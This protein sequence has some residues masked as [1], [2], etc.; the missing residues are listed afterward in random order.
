MKK[1]GKIRGIVGTVIFHVLLLLVL[2]FFGLTT[3]LPLPGEEGVEVNLGYTDDGMENIQQ[4]EAPKTTPPAPPQKTEEEV[5]EEA[6]EEIVQDDPIIEEIE[7]E[8]IITQDSDETPTITKPKDEIKEEIPEKEILEEPKEKAKEIVE[9][10]IKPEPEEKPI[11]VEKVPEKPKV[12]PRAI[13]TGKS[14][15]TDNGSNEGETG[16]PGDQGS[17]FGTKD[18]KVHDGTGGQGS[19]VSFDLG[20]RGKKHLPEP[21]Y[22]SPEQGKVVVTI[23]VNKSG[24]V[25]KAYS[26]AKGT[27]I[28]GLQLRKL[29]KDA[30]LR[31]VYNP[32]PNAPDLQ[33]GTITYNFIRLK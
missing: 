16:K 20:G 24:Q 32:D 4:S 23:Y 29:A 33:K 7:E 13:Y 2:I 26:G 9:E 10:V 30:A 22:T 11:V 5:V 18:I 3:P 19:G 1:G 25:T 14:K 28:A 8:E 6:V 27:T 15:S 12:D 17:K 21:K 31:A